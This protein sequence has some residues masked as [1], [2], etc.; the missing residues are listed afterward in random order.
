MKKQMLSKLFSSLN[1]SLFAMSSLLFLGPVRGQ[2]I[3]SSGNTSYL[4]VEYICPACTSATDLECI[5]V[6][7]QHVKPHSTLTDLVNG[8]V[9]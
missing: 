3:N 5:N 9:F 1:L 4:S 6:D 8:Y 2:T 7:M